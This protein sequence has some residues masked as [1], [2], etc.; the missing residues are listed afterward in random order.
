MFYLTNN[1]IEF[2]G[3]TFIQIKRQLPNGSFELG[4]YVEEKLPKI[5][6][7]VYIGKN[8][9]VFADCEIDGKIKVGENCI[10]RNSK[11]Y[12][13]MRVENNCKIIDSVIKGHIN[14]P[15]TFKNNC[16]ILCQNFKSNYKY[17]NY[18]FQDGKI[19]TDEYN[20]VIL[21]M[22]NN[23]CMVNCLIMTYEAAWEYL[24]NEEKWNYMMN[25]Y[26]DTPEVYYK[27]TKKWLYYWC[28]KQ[29]KRKEG[30]AK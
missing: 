10:I 9:Y 18:F 17:G 24:H 29:L 14:R 21:N 26:P 25:K 3:H 20:G 8:S 19:T 13:R 12:N 28:E 5:R 15:T 1:K 11:L 16:E 22:T 27:D 30:R 4:G 7:D 6:G 23:Y 2:E